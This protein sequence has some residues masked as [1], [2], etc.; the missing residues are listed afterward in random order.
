G[1][2]L[3]VGMGEEEALR[4]VGLGREAGQELWVAAINGPL[5]CVLSGGEEAI[6]RAERELGERGVWGRRL[7]TSHAFH[8]GMMEEAARE[9]AREM[10]GVASGEMR[11]GLVSNVTGRW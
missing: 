10:E 5:Q 3:A 1:A 11:V 7:D 4:Y 6:A 2:M 9:M 8:S